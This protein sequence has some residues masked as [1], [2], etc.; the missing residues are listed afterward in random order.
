MPQMAN[1]MVMKSKKN[2]FFSKMKCEEPTL[3]TLFVNN[4]NDNN[5]NYE[6]QN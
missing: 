6:G 1:D 3:S 4:Q 2:E 5:V